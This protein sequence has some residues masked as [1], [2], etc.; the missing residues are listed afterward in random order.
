VK[1]KFVCNLIERIALHFYCILNVGRRYDYAIQLIWK[2]I[3]ESSVRIIDFLLNK[4]QYR[5]FSLFRCYYF[6]LESSLSQF[7]IGASDSSKYGL[8]SRP[9]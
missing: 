8:R 5:A 9:M 4:L 3:D 2:K 1:V 6:V 7:E